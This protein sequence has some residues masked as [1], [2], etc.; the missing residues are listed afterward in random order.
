M[1]NSAGIASIAFGVAMTITCMVLVIAASTV[2]NAGG[3]CTNTRYLADVEYTYNVQWRQWW[4]SWS[5][6]RECQVDSAGDSQSGIRPGS[7]AQTDCSLQPSL[8]SGSGL[9]EVSKTCS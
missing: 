8:I 9:C 4:N 2:Y 3:D 5:K 6:W 7:L 1:C